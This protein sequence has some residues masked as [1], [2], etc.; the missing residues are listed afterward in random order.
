MK[1]IIK[2]GYIIEV[3]N[4]EDIQYFIVLP[5]YSTIVLSNPLKDDKLYPLDDFDDNLNYKGLSDWKGDITGIG[6]LDNQY[7][8]FSPTNIFYVWKLLKLNSL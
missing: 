8:G 6:Y 5:T 3:S 7:C 1:E 4:Q 2:P